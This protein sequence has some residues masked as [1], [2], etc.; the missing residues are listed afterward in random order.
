MV[1]GAVK[2]VFKRSLIYAFNIYSVHTFSAFLQL[3]FNPVIGL[4]LVNESVYVYKSFFVGF[5][6][7]N[8]AKSFC[9]VKEL[10]SSLK[11]CVHLL[12]IIIK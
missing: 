12:K 8:E 7:L 3:K 10:H 6:M 11:F 4:D 2:Q 9:L 5:I 1:T